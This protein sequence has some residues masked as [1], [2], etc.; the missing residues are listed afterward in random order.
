ME[1]SINVPRA[2]ACARVARRSRFVALFATARHP[3]AAYLVL[4]GGASEGPLAVREATPA[5]AAGC[6]RH[7]LLTTPD[8]G[9]KALRMHMRA[10]AQA[11]ARHASVTD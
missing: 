8:A 7:E 4:T 3:V 9:W 11:R 10:A 6:P 1:P 2:S 5:A